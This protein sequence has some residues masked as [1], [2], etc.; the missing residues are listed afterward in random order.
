MTRCWD[1]AVAVLQGWIIR[2]PGSPEID[3]QGTDIHL[4][5]MADDAVA[6]DP[7]RIVARQ[8]PENPGQS[9]R[10]LAWINELNQGCSRR[11]GVVLIGYSA[12]GHAVL[13]MSDPPQLCSRIVLDPFEP[14]LRADQRN[15]IRTAPGGHPVKHFYPTA[16]FLFAGLEVWGYSVSGPNVQSIAVSGSNHLDLPATLSRGPLRG[17]VTSSVRQCL[18][19]RSVSPR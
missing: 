19:E 8:F 4:Q 16:P 1:V 7:A 2:L 14:S 12:G 18:A 3:P 11:P 13:G 5:T 6:V 15:S 9:G 17:E 10:A